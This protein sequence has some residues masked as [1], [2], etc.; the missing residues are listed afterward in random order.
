MCKPYAAIPP[1]PVFLR[2]DAA[3]EE[4]A[5]AL[6]AIAV[7]CCS[8]SRGLPDAS[9]EVPWHH[10]VF[11]AAAGPLSAQA[12][13]LSATALLKCLRA[14]SMHLLAEASAARTSSL[15]GEPAAS[16]AI[17]GSQTSRLPLLV[18]G[19]S[20]TRSP[21]EELPAVAAEALSSRLS[22]LPAHSVV[23][24]LHSLYCLEAKG[25]L[26]EGQSAAFRAA[27]VEELGR[28]ERLSQLSVRDLGYA[29][30][31]LTFSPGAPIR[32]QPKLC[33]LGRSLLNEVLLHVAT[34]TPEDALRLLRA[35]AF[36][37]RSARPEQAIDV[38]A[39]EVMRELRVFGPQRL[40]DTLAA[41]SQ[42]RMKETGL[43]TN[44]GE[45]VASQLARCP[46][47]QLAASLHSLAKLGL[48]QGPVFRE[49]AP[50]IVR[51]IVGFTYRD[52][53]TCLWAFAK[54]GQKDTAL[55][56]RV[57]DFLKGQ[58]LS[59]LAPADVSM[60]L[61]SYSRLDWELDPDLLSSFTHHA[62]VGCHNCSKTSLLVT[63]LALGRLG[64]ARQ[65]VLV[66]L[67]RSL[68]GRLPD[69]T[70]SQLALAFLLFSGS[71]IRDAA[72]LQRLLFE[73]SQRLPRLRGQDLSNVV[74]ACSRLLPAPEPQGQD[75]GEV[76][77]GL[78]DALRKRVL[79]QLEQLPPE[80]L[81]GIFQAAP[82]F[83]GFSQEE[84]LRVTTSLLRH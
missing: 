51:D 20:L 73:S 12:E 45:A 57:Q 55:L 19:P 38:I 26:S 39:A 24:A 16:W 34:L 63:C 43:V 1:V 21:V 52:L 54:A 3:P 56:S 46:P 81:L 37:P 22:E 36:L 18:T 11:A 14:F 66:E 70:D 48:R 28:A 58:N 84:S 75:A 76:I 59:R 5:E 69:L 77:P 82:K 29:L 44:L 8:R 42:I 65:P 4:L 50:Q 78:H 40:C 13:T 31:A 47:K 71:G 49:A 80:P 10:A 17:E 79:D 83:L 53:A 9:L 72:L 62:A 67:Y 15:A 30:Q 68:Y 33:Q 23:R 64:F 25:L 2:F 32:D 60:L 41:F 74:L 6:L 35:A 27:A 61:W 7:V